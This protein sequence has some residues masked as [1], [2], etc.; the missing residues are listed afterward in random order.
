MRV[1]RPAY[2]AW[3]GNQYKNEVGRLLAAEYNAKGVT[4][5]GVKYDAGYGTLSGSP[6]TTD[7]NTMINAYI[8]YCTWRQVGENPQ[9]SYQ[10][11][12][13]CAGDDGINAT[14]PE[15]VERV[16]RDL[17]LKVKLEVSRRGAA[18]KFLSRIFVDPWGSMGSFQ[19]PD[20]TIKKLHISFA[21]SEVTDEEAVYNRAE[22]YLTLDPE[23]PIVSN[24]CRKVLQ[25][26][27]P[28]VGERAHK[29]L[30]RCDKDVPYYK[31]AWPQVTDVEFAIQRYA[32][33]LGIGS[34]QVRAINRL[35]D[36][37]LDYRH[38][39]PMLITSRNDKL[40]NVADGRQAPLKISRAP[41]K[42]LTQP[43]V[44]PHDSGLASPTDSSATGSRGSTA[45]RRHRHRY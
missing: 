43:R 12:G 4:K 7:G 41:R 19:D 29:V 26:L 31:V 42:K 25:T 20:R 44:Y 14:P 16:S 36:G 37:A 13:L 33:S 32:E 39:R 18:V 40:V 10:R 28:V 22:G 3:A 27:G 45:R 5:F 2:L 35:I 21:P 17:G 30:T 34:E 23:A 8:C 6:R 11:I 24:W 1:V 15:V 9:K 38:L